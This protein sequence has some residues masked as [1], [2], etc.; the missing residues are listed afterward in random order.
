MFHGFLTSLARR[1]V[2]VLAT[3]LLVAAASSRAHAQSWYENGDAGDLI[4]TAQTTI[5]AGSLTSV[6]GSLQF[7]SDVDLYCINV[8][9]APP[10]GVTLLALYCTI[11]QGPCLWLF[12]AA[13]NGVLANETCLG[14]YKVINIPVGSIPAGTYYVAVT[15]AGREP[16]SYGGDMWLSGV[17]GLRAPDG[18]GA[19]GPLVG[20]TGTPL[21]GPQNPYTF[22]LAF[23]SYCNAATPAARP[24]WGGLKSIYR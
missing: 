21:V 1:F 18:P 17:P 15:Y 6:T 14:G 24:T 5:G 19:G 7:D 2:H 13:G 11:N 9:S 8:P 16:Y 10:V 22:G 23:S 12:D 4:A 20:W 3:V